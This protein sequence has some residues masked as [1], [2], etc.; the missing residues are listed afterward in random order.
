MT[1]K[2]DR[3][4]PF[5]R[6]PHLSVYRR[7]ALLVALCQGLALYWLDRLRGETSTNAQPGPRRAEI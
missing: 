7:R 3:E 4:D 6:K 1:A 5:E 2:V